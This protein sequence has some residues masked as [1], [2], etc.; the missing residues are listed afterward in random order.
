[1]AKTKK[2]NLGLREVIITLAALVSI[3]TGCR[4]IFAWVSGVV[5]D[6]QIFVCDP[7]G[8]P[9]TDVAIE[10]PS[11]T[12]YPDAHG[13]IIACPEWIDEMITIHDGKTWQLLGRQKLTRGENERFIKLI[14]PKQFEVIE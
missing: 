9:R 4:F 6:F 5:A 14:I 11:G 10:T 1:M 2:P 12:R 3:I 7:D 8:F 13:K